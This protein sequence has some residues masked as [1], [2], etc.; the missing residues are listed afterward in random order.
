MR[1]LLIAII[2]LGVIL[3]YGTP[4]PW[5]FWIALVNMITYLIV[6]F[7]IPNEIAFKAMKR[8]TAKVEAAYQQGAT[9]ERLT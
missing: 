6:S 1:L 7:T 8:H 5:L 9:E 2:I 4:Y 3:S